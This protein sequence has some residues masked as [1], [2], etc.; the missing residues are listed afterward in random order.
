MS[1]HY[2]NGLTLED[3]DGDFFLFLSKTIAGFW[4]AFHI[5]RVWLKLFFTQMMLNAKITKARDIHGNI[6]LH[7]FKDETKHGI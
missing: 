6:C 2:L 5:M 3:V 4:L 1:G 7:T